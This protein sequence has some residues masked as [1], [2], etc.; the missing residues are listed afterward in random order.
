M[1]VTSAA[2]WSGMSAA[3]RLGPSCA[4]TGSLWRGRRRCWSLRLVASWLGVFGFALMFNSPWA[5]GD[6]VPPTIGMVANV[7]PNSS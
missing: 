3:L 1:I 4:A 2:W 6:R 7:G 5:D